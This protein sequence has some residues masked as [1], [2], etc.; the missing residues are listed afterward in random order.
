MKKEKV[1]IIIP[2]YNEEDNIEKTYQ[3][4]LEYNS[5]HKTNYDVLVVDDGSF[6]QTKKILTEHAIPHIS[7]ITNLGIG[8][9]VQTGYKYALEHEYDIAIQLDG[10]G[11]HN[12]DDLEKLIQPI[13]EKKADMVIGSRFVKDSKSQFKSSQLRRVGIRLISTIIKWKTKEKIYDTTSGFRAINRKLIKLFT[14]IY[15]MEYPEPISTVYILARGYK[16]K[17][18]GVRMKDR[19]GGK[20]SIHTWKNVYYMINVILNILLMKRGKKDAN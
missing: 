9:A 13:L 20:S 11:Q 3:S 2:A 7:L 5:N 18:I 12:T 14:E 8:G 19:E 15:P 1:L 16:V 17:E 10:D 4:I 6:D